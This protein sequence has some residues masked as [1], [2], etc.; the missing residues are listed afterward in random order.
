MRVLFRADA[1]V[2]QGSGHVMRCLT[3]AEAFT[4]RGDEV[5]FVS[6]IDSIPWLVSHM[7]DAGYRTFAVDAHS[8]DAVAVLPLA[9]DWVVVD[10]YV[11][12]AGDITALAEEVPVLAIVDGDARGIVATLFLDQNLGA[13]PVSGYEER[14]LAG[15][16]YALIRDAVL[17][18]RRDQPWLVDG[19]PRVTAFMG[20]TDS[21]GTIV[22]VARQLALVGEAFDVVVVCPPAF[23]PDV[24]DALGPTVTVL[25][26]TPDLPRIL[27]GSNVIVS[28]AG[29]S[30]W[31]ICTLGVPALLVGVVDNQS[32]SLQR[33]TAGGLVLGIDLVRGGSLEELPGAVRL[34]LTDV[35]ARET[36]SRHSTAAFDGEGKR[37]VLEAMLSGGAASA[38]ALTDSL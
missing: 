22:A 33:A 18:G 20:G 6:A 7:A 36:L 37:R 10:S 15:A 13:T 4:A 19:V 17:D 28:A 2:R 26:P 30:A 27:A 38:H 35:G 8:L 29:T 14:S 1:S 31:D 34:L 25:A 21:S 16:P 12:P 11:I 32:A 9:P 24:V 23:H 3:L 5:I